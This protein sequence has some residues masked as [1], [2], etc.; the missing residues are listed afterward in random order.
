M[1]NTTLDLLYLILAVGL[2][3]L[4]FT[5]SLLVVKWIQFMGHVNHI[6]E[7][8]D[9]ITDSVNTYVKLPATA[10]YHIIQKIDKKK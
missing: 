7:K 3:L 1:I 8:V 2:G 4:L 9:E 5:L 10:L 6:S